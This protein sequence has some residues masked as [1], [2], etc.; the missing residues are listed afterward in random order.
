MLR[1]ITMCT[2]VLGI[3]GLSGA[4]Y[5]HGHHR[6]AFNP[7]ICMQLNIKSG[8]SQSLGQLSMNTKKHCH[9]RMR[10]GYPIPDPKCTPGAIN[11]TVTS[12]V[13]RDPYFFKAN[14]V[15]NRVTTEREKAA[16]YRWYGI[17]P[18]GDKHGSR[19]ICE[20]DYL[21]PLEL[22]GADTLD[23]VWPECGPANVPVWKRYFRRKDLVE[24]YLTKR[25]EEGKMK[26]WDAQQGIAKDWTQYLPAAMK[27]CI[28][29]GCE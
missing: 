26:L 12:A 6:Y 21:V 20:L 5:A 29:G 1:I 25:V 17:R 19:Q 4:A 22:G 8:M 13:L 14:C 11:P 16:T 9:T 23:N 24:G 3:V 27:A 7:S 28:P 15:R 2:L 18:R 10:N